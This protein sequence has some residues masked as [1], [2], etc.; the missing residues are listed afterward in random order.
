MWSRCCSRVLARLACAAALATVLVLQVVEPPLV[1]AIPATPP[2]PSPAPRGIGL[3]PFFAGGEQ[4]PLLRAW[5]RSQLV[6]Q[7]PVLLA[8]A[9]SGYDAGSSTAGGLLNTY[10]LPTD[11]HLQSVPNY[12]PAELERQKGNQYYRQAPSRPDSP[13][14]LRDEVAA[15]KLLAD[16]TERVGGQALQLDKDADLFALLV[17]EVDGVGDKIAVFVNDATNTPVLGKLFFVGLEHQFNACSAI[18]PL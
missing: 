14:P 6:R 18:L 9:T 17:D 13:D 5:L 16:E 11:Q 3:Q 10:R 1:Y 8:Q 4:D 12:D 15:S 7:L 2:A